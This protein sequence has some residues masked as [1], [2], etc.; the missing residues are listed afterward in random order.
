MARSTYYD[1]LKRN[2][3]PDKYAKVKVFIRKE[4]LKTGSRYGYRRIHK[5]AVEAGFNYAEETIRKI[6]TAMGLKV[7]LFSKHTSKYSSY[8]GSV[9]KIAPNLLKQ[10][11]N[12]TKPLTV[13]HTDV[14]QV[15]LYNGKWG[16]I[17][18][19]I[20]EA[21]KEVLSAVASYSP[22]KKLITDT[23][24][25]VQ[26]H[27]IR[28]FHPILHSDQGWQYQ[29]PSYQ[30]RLK[31]MGITQSMSRKGNCHDNAPVESFFSLLKRECL[32][33]YKIENI[34]ELNGILKSYIAWFNKD[35]ISMKTKGLSPINYRNQAS[36]A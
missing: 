1:R 19:I 15:P 6:M 17:S 24:D 27:I 13:M 7:T 16:Y 4:Y 29:L 26:N 10:R 32:N 5:K 2:L 22:N 20:D 23:L 9:G 11:F 3:K 36:V 25:Q 14:T 30:A 33:K 21:S 8:K 12:A 34:T 28:G 31:H 18:V 35:R